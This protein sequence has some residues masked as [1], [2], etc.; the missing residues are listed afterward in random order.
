MCPLEHLKKIVV[1]IMISGHLYVLNCGGVSKGIHP[2]N[3]FAEKILIVVAIKF[4]EL[5]LLLLHTPISHFISSR[6]KLHCIYKHE[7]DIYIV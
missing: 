6:E 2:V 4:N 3:T 7:K 5:I 1:E